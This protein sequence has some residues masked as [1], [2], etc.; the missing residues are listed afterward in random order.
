MTRTSIDERIA[1]HENRARALR[2][3]KTKQDRAR[4]TR[5]KIIIGA[6]VL[7]RLHS[8]ADTDFSRRFGAW[9][10]REIPGFISR[11]VDQKLVAEM[12]LEP[13]ENL[14]NQSDPATS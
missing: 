10:R 3:R 13:E 7:H 11:E 1:T 8:E 12:L 5:G 9:I 2:A 4:D 6:F 14:R